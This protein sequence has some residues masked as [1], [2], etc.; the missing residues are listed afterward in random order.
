M[1]LLIAIS[2]PRVEDVVMHSQPLSNGSISV[3]V[4]IADGVWPQPWC[5]RQVWMHK[6]FTG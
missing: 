2:G 4:S 6:L 5:R 1:I 3:R